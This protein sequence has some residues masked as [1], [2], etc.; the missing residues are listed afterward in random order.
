MFI[1]FNNTWSI[2]M[3]TDNPIRILFV[4]DLPSDMELA[5]HELR[6]ESIPFTS[7]R[8]ETREGF[9]KALEEFRPDLIISDYALPEFD[10]MQA[11]KLWR[12]QY[13]AIPFIILTGSMNEETAVAC[14]KAGATDYVIKE[15]IK[16]LPFAVQEALE[17]QRIRSEKERAEQ[18][19]RESEARFRKML[20]M[21]PLP[22][23]YVDKNGVITFR[24]KR[25]DQVFGYTANDVPTL[26]E[27]WPHAYP[28]AQ[29]RQWVTGTWD[30]AVK[31]AAEE[32]RDID[33]I[34]YRV[35][36]RSGEERIVEI[37]GITL[38][39]DFLA[40]FIDLTE[41][42]RAEEAV[43]KS[44]IKYHELFDTMNDGFVITDLKGTILECNTAYAEMLGYEKE[45]LKRLSYQD[46]TPPKW[47]A[48]EEHIVN[49]QFLKRGYSDWYEKEYI[50]KDGSNFSVSH[51]GRLLKDDKGL[52]IGMWGFIRNITE[53]KKAREELKES[54]ARYRALFESIND[55]VFV[56]YV[57]DAGVPGSFSQVN[58]VAC[59][60]LGYTREELLAMS[61]RD[62]TSPEAYEII[63][64]AREMLVS[65]GEVIIET[66]HVT[67]DGRQIPVESSVCLFNYLG[68]Q[69]AISIARDITE[70]K[71]AEAEQ[72]KL[73]AQLF[74]SQK[75]ET[76]GH[77][78]GGIAH[79]FNNILAAIIGYA[80]LLQTEMNK[81]DPLYSHVEHIL[82]SSER[83]AT[84]VHSLL[85][86]SRKQTLSVKPINI[87]DLVS[88][89]SKL[90]V[91]LLGEDIILETV[92]TFM[93]PMVMVD[94]GQIDQILFNLST[95]ARDA[96]PDGGHL[97]ITTDITEIDDTYIKEHSY[98]LAGD[99]ALITV[100]D[101][102][103]GMDKDT[104]EKIFE[105]F[106]T[107]KE[108]GKGTGLGLS[109]AYGIV[110]QHNGFINCY[111]EP[112]KGTTFKIYLPLLE[113]D[114]KAVSEQTGKRTEMMSEGNET[115]LVAE[116]DVT[117][118]EL[119]KY[120]LSLYGY[121]IYEAEDGAQA[122]QVFTDHAQ[123]INLLLFDVIMPRKNGKEAYQEIQNIRPGVPVIFTSGYT[124]DIVHKKGFL[125]E[126]FE[127]LLKPVSMTALLQKVREVLDKNREQA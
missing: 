108:V 13:P 67:K 66:V 52:P 6:R 20:E 127:I 125:D 51:R 16:R 5:E 8:V 46:L 69:A 93:D 122:V 90:L 80:D 35:T 33:S 37:S 57:E 103:T 62:I 117:V 47:H 64:A 59:K 36:C 111:S 49:N 24:N 55:A 19:L 23:C 38:G 78:A 26:A 76:V 104:Q 50:R 81:A 34:E 56:H 79:D 113:S 31:R 72:E 118:R 126:G 53:E 95:N 3:A 97:T 43:K 42:K 87:N 99:Y 124:A 65:K 2:T 109:T 25:F 1:L 94:A 73:R 15:R 41:R 32:G 58:D 75:M 96:M 85:A 101:T 88:G 40:T 18:A 29:Y 89:V 28:D 44:E 17:Q 10:G 86:F 123:E 12:Q 110:K 27:W 112:G 82:T 92:F 115:I 21:M 116:D 14:M 4:E 71:R 39:D 119:L 54:E 106:F 107:T 77:L 63:S 45:E 100:S 68:R 114:K 105:P 60:R 9:L 102:G 70:R 83:A 98:G 22:L 91:R 84:L 48:I 11:L 61:P 120:I 74:Q 30:A 7:M 121:T